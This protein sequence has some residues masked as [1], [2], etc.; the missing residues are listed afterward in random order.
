M[1]EQ[2]KK[3]KKVDHIKQ[4]FANFITFARVHE[5]VEKEFQ[6]AKLAASDLK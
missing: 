5:D 2:K 3:E 1:K 4:N 6:S